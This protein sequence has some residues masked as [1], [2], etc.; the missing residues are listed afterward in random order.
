MDAR[1]SFPLGLG[2]WCQGRGPRG[3]VRIKV[4]DRAVG[5]ARTLRSG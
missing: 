1:A 4:E 5:P 2:F 3:P